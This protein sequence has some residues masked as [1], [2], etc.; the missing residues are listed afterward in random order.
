MGTTKKAAMKLFL[1]VLLEN[2]IVVKMMPKDLQVGVIH[3]LAVLMDQAMVDNMVVSAM[4]R[5]E[6]LNTHPQGSLR[7]IVV[8][9]V[10][11]NSNVM[12]QDMGT[13]E[14]PLMSCTGD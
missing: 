12:D 13:G 4:V 10:G 7:D 3:M 11:M 2:L 9:G 6:M 5:M 8:L 14:H 1:M